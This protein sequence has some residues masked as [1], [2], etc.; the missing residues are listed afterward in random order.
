MTIDPMSKATR[1]VS[2]RAK[3]RRR[4]VAL[5]A[6]GVLASVALVGPPADAKSCLRR[7]YV[8]QAECNRR[9]GER[10][11]F[12]DGVHMSPVSCNTHG[13]LD[14]L[15]GYGYSISWWE[16]CGAGEGEGVFELESGVEV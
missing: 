5:L 3:R 4:R 1:P 7:E 16:K 14:W 6:T 11:P 9:D 2:S 10:V 15:R 13:W 12:G 8:S